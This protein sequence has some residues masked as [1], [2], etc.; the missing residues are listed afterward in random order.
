MAEY[1]VAFNGEHFIILQLNMILFFL[2]F[3]VAPVSTLWL[4][5]WVCIDGRDSD[6]VILIS[7]FAIWST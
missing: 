1:I 5:D 7:I 2:F 6:Q 3:N 4:Q